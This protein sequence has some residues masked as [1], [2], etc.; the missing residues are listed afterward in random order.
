MQFL[1]LINVKDK[2]LDKKKL[3][4]QAFNEN[5]N[6]LNNLTLKLKLE[7]VCSTSLFDLRHLKVFLLI[8]EYST[9]KN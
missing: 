7:K 1:Q 9:V 3:N 4:I 5:D 6:T 2:K 8:G